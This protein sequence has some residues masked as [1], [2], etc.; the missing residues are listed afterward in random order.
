MYNSKNK[1]QRAVSNLG[2]IYGGGVQLQFGAQQEYIMSVV[3]KLF[4]LAVME[5]IGKRE[6]DT[7]VSSR[8][9]QTCFYTYYVCARVLRVT[10]SVVTNSRETHRKSRYFTHSVCMRLCAVQHS[11]SLSLFTLDSFVQGIMKVSTILVSLGRAFQLSCL[12]QL[13]LKCIC[14]QA[15]CLTQTCAP[16]LLCL[17]RSSFSGMCLSH[18]FLGCQKG[19]LPRDLQLGSTLGLFRSFP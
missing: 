15:Q 9:R 18:E 17:K 4:T 12:G 19:R 1:F 7:S 6:A 11:L 2:L 10:S 5:D 3:I 14:Q 8:Q 13:N 16:S